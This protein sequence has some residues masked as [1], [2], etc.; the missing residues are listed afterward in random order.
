MFII[1]HAMIGIN[2]AVFAI[3]HTVTGINIAISA[4]YHTKRN[5]YSNMCYTTYM[6]KASI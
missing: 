6:Y 3:H 5:I 4:T 1:H 2:T